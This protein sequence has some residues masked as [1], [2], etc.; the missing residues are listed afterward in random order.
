MLRWCSD[1]KMLASEE[2]LSKGASSMRNQI[3]D[4]LQNW[5][6]YDAKLYAFGGI[7]W[8][9]ILSQHL[10]ETNAELVYALENF[11]D[12]DMDLPA[13][14]FMHRTTDID[15]FVKCEIS[16]VDDLFNAI[17][18]FLRTNLAH[19][20]VHQEHLHNNDYSRHRILVNTWYHPLAEKLTIAIDFVFS[21]D[22]SYF[23][24]DL[25]SNQLC[26]DLK[27]GE[28]NLFEPNQNSNSWFSSEYDLSLIFNVPVA[29][30]VRSILSGR[31]NTK[32]IALAAI[33][34]DILKFVSRILIYSFKTWHALQQKSNDL[35]SVGRYLA[36]AKKIVSHRAVKLL[37]NNVN[38]LGFRYKIFEN[39]FICEKGFMTPLENIELVCIDAYDIKVDNYFGDEHRNYVADDYTKFTTNFYCS[40]CDNYHLLLNQEL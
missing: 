33:K 39:N 3:L 29:K 10:I 40:N 26:I 12:V 6:F 20:E 4:V 27:N 21:S 7:V 25:S 19:L 36:Y 38:V 28:L 14:T 34:D 24:P 35:S 16:D 23:F 2:K 32:S 9:S 1:S 37:N 18:I 5:R 17:V 11:Q 22:Y 13:G 31:N 30:P 8:K 15:I